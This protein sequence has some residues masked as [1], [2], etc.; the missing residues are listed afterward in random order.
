MGGVFRSAAGKWSRHLLESR[1]TRVPNA[2]QTPSRRPPTQSLEPGSGRRPA[3]GNSK[4]AARPDLDSAESGAPGQ[5]AGRAGR[6]ARGTGTSG[7]AACNSETESPPNTSVGF[8]YSRGRLPRQGPP[9]PRGGVEGEGGWQWRENKTP[10]FPPLFF[11]CSWC[12][13]LSFSQPKSNNSL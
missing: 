5:Q 8:K 2:D 12:R 4:T 9:K 6:R 7:D 10:F 3:S 1:E 11:F 13:T